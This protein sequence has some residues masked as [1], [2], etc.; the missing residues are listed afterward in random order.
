MKRGRG[1]RE[2]EEEKQK[3]K[4]EDI[5][6]ENRIQSYNKGQIN[7]VSGKEKKI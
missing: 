7:S 5:L 2:E 1:R 6:T 4:K 3:N